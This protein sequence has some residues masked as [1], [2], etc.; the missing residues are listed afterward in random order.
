MKQDSCPIVYVIEGDPIA[1]A[2]GRHV[3]R[4]VYDS[5]KNEK[6][7]LRI[8]LRNQHGDRPL[9]QGPLLLNA[10]FYMPIAKSR[11]KHKES[12]LDSAHFYTP[13]L[14]NLIKFI[15]DI[16]KDILY[17]DDC[18]ISKIIA[19]KIYGEPRTEFT[20]TKLK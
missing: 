14:S 8:T 11:E 19:K 20:L 12:L 9:Y 17:H 7:V 16:A 4:R 3:G 15:E 5:Q 13:D 6:L 1:L 10:T 2:R 18:L